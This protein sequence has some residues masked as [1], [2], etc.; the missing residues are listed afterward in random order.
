M[1][2]K[3]APRSIQT[4]EP[5][6]LKSVWFIPDATCDSCHFPADNLLRIV[7][8]VESKETLRGIAE[9]GLVLRLSQYAYGIIH[10]G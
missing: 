6:T 1:S 10:N 7:E 9:M 8:L 2:S 4:V 3:E 5:P